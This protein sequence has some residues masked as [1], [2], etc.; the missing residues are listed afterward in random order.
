MKEPDAD[1]ENNIYYNF[2]WFSDSSTEPDSI[3]L[4][5]VLKALVQMTF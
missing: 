3:Y 1:T 5:T 4:V 2:Q